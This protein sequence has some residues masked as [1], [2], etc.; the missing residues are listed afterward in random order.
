MR[1]QNQDLKLGSVEGKY[2]MLAKDHGGE[3]EST[4]VDAREDL[5]WIWYGVTQ[6]DVMDLPDG[7]KFAP[8]RP[9]SMDVPPMA[10]YGSI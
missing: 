9:G 2:K 10:M 8:P 1:S 7:G 5:S 4:T 3:V 6:C